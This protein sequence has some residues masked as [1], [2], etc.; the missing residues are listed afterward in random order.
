MSSGLRLE[1]NPLSTTTFSS[2]RS[3]DLENSVRENYSFLVVTESIR[4]FNHAVPFVPYEIRTVSGETYE[5]PHPDFIL[6]PPKGSYVV[7]M[8]PRI[9]RRVLTTSARC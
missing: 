1:I 7:V 8:I 6:V 2:T 4:K 5:I 9:P 3:E